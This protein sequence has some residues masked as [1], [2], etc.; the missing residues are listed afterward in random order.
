MKKFKEDGKRLC[1]IKNPDSN[2]PDLELW[3]KNH[4]HCLFCEHCTTEMV[5]ED[6]KLN[7]EAFCNLPSI[8]AQKNNCLLHNLNQDHTCA[9][10]KDVDGDGPGVVMVKKKKQEPVLPG[11]SITKDG[12]E[13]K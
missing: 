2:G 12:V 11:F 5:L 3:C 6:G 7:V 8:S 1:T 4:K 13:E 10:F 9:A